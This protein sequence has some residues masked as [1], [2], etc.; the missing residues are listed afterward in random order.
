MQLS[1]T[2]QQA[3]RVCDTHKPAY[4]DAH[5]PAY[6][7]AGLQ[8]DAAA[9]P[10]AA[11]LACR[12]GMIHSTIC[13]S[14]ATETTLLRAPSVWQAGSAYPGWLAV[15][16]LSKPLSCSSHQLCV[17]FQWC[18]CLGVRL[19][20]Y[21]PAYLPLT[22]DLGSFSVLDISAEDSKQFYAQHPKERQVC[23]CVWGGHHGSQWLQKLNLQ[24]APTGTQA[25][26]RLESIE[27]PLLCCCSMLFAESHLS[28]IQQCCFGQIH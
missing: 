21:P 13:Y 3:T 17:S 22:G 2:L 5:Q 11:C 9:L 12:K 26:G 10:A 28:V 24:A 16:M 18:T 25:I 1:D 14:F 20:N 19:L 6:N 4:S 27:E 23:V 15:V 8:V 7:T